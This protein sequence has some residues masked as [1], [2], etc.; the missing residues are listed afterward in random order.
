[1]K[2]R[3]GPSSQLPPTESD[4][5]RQRGKRVLCGPGGL[6]EAQREGN[7]PCA[8]FR[9]R[10][11]LTAGLGV[12]GLATMNNGIIQCGYYLLQVLPLECL[13]RARFAA[14]GVKHDVIHRL[15]HGPPSNTDSG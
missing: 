4:D 3:V 14:R 8:A 12:I 10:S 13:E 2:V 11:V 6:H 7:R 15:L 1:M 5:E 9:A